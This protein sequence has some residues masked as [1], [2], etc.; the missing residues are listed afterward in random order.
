MPSLRFFPA[1]AA[2]LTAA[3]ALGPLAGCAAINSTGDTAGNAATW[4][5]A[6]S[7]PR[8]TTSSRRRAPSPARTAT[9]EEEAPVS[10]PR[11]RPVVHAD[12]PVLLA[13]S[14]A[15]SSAA[16][17]I[18][19]LRNTGDRWIGVRYRFGG[20]TRSGIDCSAFTREMFRETFGIELPRNT[21]L[22][23]NEGF[24]VD[25]DELQPGDLVFFRRGGTRHVGVYLGDGNFIHASSS[26]GVT[27][28]R[29]DESYY[30]RHYWTARRILT[31][32]PASF[33]EGG[34]RRRPLPR[35]EREALRN[36][37]TQA[38]PTLSDFQNGFEWN[39][40]EEAEAP[41]PTEEEHAGW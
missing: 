8:V 14:A 31:S 5:A 24:Q 33:T 2:A 26:R 11:V 25:R 9:P 10:A 18:A 29:L 35:A 28:S 3:L 6:A 30:A 41:A 37:E 4:T 1:R 32:T 39:G 23:V 15:P 34:V 21:A 16:A 19:S 13:E 38:A 40:A 12:E 20:E 36:G 27:Y 17:L 7:S 22:Q